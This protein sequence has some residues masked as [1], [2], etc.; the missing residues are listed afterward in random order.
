MATPFDY[1]SDRHCSKTALVALV[2]RPAFD[3]QSDRHCS[4]TR[5]TRCS[6]SWGLIT[7]QIDTAPKLTDVLD[8]VVGG[9]ITSQID[10][11]PKPPSVLHRRVGV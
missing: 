1:Q 4:K 7:S 8:A 5:P 6:S 3:Y 9:L 2:P 11:A 10:T